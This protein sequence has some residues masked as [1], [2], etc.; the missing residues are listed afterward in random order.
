MTPLAFAPRAH[1]HLFLPHSFV[2]A[3][4]PARP[5]GCQMEL[6]RSQPVQTLLSPVALEGKPSSEAKATSP[7]QI[8]LLCHSAASGVFVYFLSVIGSLAD[9]LFKVI[10]APGR[11]VNN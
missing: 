8:P 9:F 7:R 3:W 6:T 5:A 1:H 4:R 10:S 2:N 11:V